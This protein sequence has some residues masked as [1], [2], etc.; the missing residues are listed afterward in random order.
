VGVGVRFRAARLTAADL[1]L[2]LVC[3]FTCEGAAVGPLPVIDLGIA[4]FG[5]TA[6]ESIALPPGTM[7]EGVQLSLPS[8]VV[9]SGTAT[10]VH[11]SPGRI[12]ARF[13]SGTI[14]LRRLRLEATVEGR[15]ATLREQRERLPPEWR[16]AVSDVRQLL[17]DA[18]TEV[19]QLDQRGVEDPLRRTEE[20]AALFETFRAQWAREYYGAIA[21]LHEK[22][23]SLDERGRVVGSLYAEAALMPLLYACPMH[24]RAYEKPLGYAGD[25]RLM[26]LCFADEPTA[27]SL[28]GR[29]VQ[30]VGL[31]YSLVR[32]VR[33]REAVMR[34]AVERVVYAETTQP[35]RVLSVAAGPAL[36]LRRL[37][38][39]E[40]AASISRPVEFVLLDQ[41]DSALE[42][43]HRHLTRLL[44]ERHGGLLPVTV[45]CLHLSIRQLLKPQSPEE[46]EAADSIAAPDL[47]Y[48]AGLY[49]YLPDA[50]CVWLTS[51]L[52]SRLRPGGQL[53]L[54]NM[55]ETPD[56]T[57]LMDYVVDWPLYY[58]TET[59]ML[60][61]AKRL[62][63]SAE[64]L[65]IA[66]DA[67]GYCLFLDAT[68]PS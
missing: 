68:R 28:F 48:S 43:A 62:A 22:S 63:P 7:L 53:L 19:E 50:F 60:A 11:G 32:A 59:S 34:D 29:F 39:S 3:T 4:G 36:E 2:D 45:S 12:G 38:D 1:P 58:R 33:G 27:E 25:Y 64:R 52:Y 40:R 61:L 21:D 46:R 17:E 23:R 8:R 35:A 26:E 49:D 31:G 16:A 65:A 56:S 14:D 10:V 51:F 47:I 66:R 30:T 9:W 57:W 18:R 6:P 5:A 37:L 24:A 13:E 41:D 42:A 15:L 67:S 20:E 55:A 54:G 44:L